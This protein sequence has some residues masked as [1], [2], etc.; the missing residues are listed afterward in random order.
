MDNN[1]NKDNTG[2]TG[3]NDNI[4]NNNNNTDNKS[5]P[6]SP[7][8]LTTSASSS[9]GNGTSAPKPAPFA[10][11]VVEKMKGYLD[12][13]ENSDF[14]GNASSPSLVTTAARSS[15]YS[16]SGDGTLWT[17]PA[18]FFIPVLYDTELDH[19][20]AICMSMPIE[21]LRGLLNQT[22]MEVPQHHRTVIQEVLEFKLAMQK[23]LARG[24]LKP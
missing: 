18:P 8:Q 23:G 10:D 24:L 12:R 14:S 11:E 3:N 21:Q 2:N 9:S 15:S 5:D 16:S 7:S 6:S 17:N 22:R 1:N 13:G 20:K 19:L 4:A